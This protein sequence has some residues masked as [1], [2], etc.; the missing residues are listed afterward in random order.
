MI[1]GILGSTGF[2]GQN[3]QSELNEQSIK[4]IGASRRTG[5]D[6][7]NRVTLID[8]ILYHKISHLIN[9]AAEC[10]GIG[11]NQKR[12]ADLW[13]ATAK[14]TANVLDVAR[15]TKIQ[16][17]IQ[18]GTVCSYPKDCPVP[19]KEEYLMNYG[20]PEPTNLAYGIA[21]LSSLYGA[22]AYIKQY[23]MNITNLIPVNMYGPMDHFDPEV[24]HVI[25]ALIR[26]M[27]VAKNNNMSEV[28]LWGTGKASR[29]F[30]HARDFARSAILALNKDT[31]GQ[32][33]NI[34]TGSE[35]SIKDLATMIAEIIGYNGSIIWDSTR[36]DGQPRRCLDISR[37][38]NILGYKPSIN[39]EDGL[40]GTIEWFL[41]KGGA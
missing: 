9:L 8:W 33:I 30:L 11:L 17:L 28:I 13:L 18:V 19:F 38:T 5:L 25:P 10:G 26:K 1:V 32:F 29:E 41:E 35:I 3:L 21:K 7:T 20:E 16:H 2:V 22:Q 12:P 39:L 31:N 37:A 6:A 27:H 24:S 36:P 34:G 14:I 40:R 23:K 4:F 15:I